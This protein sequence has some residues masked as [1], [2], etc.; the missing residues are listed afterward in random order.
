[1]AINNKTIINGIS[2]LTVNNFTPT[3]LFASNFAASTTKDNFAQKSSGTL[4]S[5]AWDTFTGTDA[6]TGFTWPGASANMPHAMPGSP[7]QLNW[8]HVFLMNNYATTMTTVSNYGTSVISS[9][10]GAGPGGST[11]QQ[12]TLNLKDTG[13]IDHGVNEPFGGQLWLMLNRISGGTNIPPSDLNDLYISYYFKHTSTTG[14]T[15]PNDGLLAISDF[16]TGGY[17]NLYGGDFRIFTGIYK[18]ASGNL[19]WQATCDAAANGTMT[20]APDTMKPFVNTAGDFWYWKE[21]NKTIPVTFNA[22]HKFELYIHRH[23]T[24]GIFLWGIDDQIAC[25]HQGRTLGE[26]GL[27]WGRLMAFGIYS[28]YGPGQGSMVRLNCYDYPP[29]GSVLQDQAR[30]ML[31]W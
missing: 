5:Q 31:A 16:K 10:A 17:S 4:P 20:A 23:A 28:S 19:M 22:W 6:S 24:K 30:K 12:L 11:E 18:D 29:N 14:S 8:T 3:Q 1:M 27:Q 21:S 26:F 25:A 15:L 7:M 9:T 2:N 13:L